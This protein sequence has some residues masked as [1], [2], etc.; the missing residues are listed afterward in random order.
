MVFG[1]QTNSKIDNDDG[2]IVTRQFRRTEP[3]IARHNETIYIDHGLPIIRPTLETLVM[4]SLVFQLD[5][6]LPSSSFGIVQQPQQQRMSTFV[7]RLNSALTAGETNDENANDM[8]VPNAFILDQQPRERRILSTA[9]L[10]ETIDDAL[11]ISALDNDDLFLQ[12]QQ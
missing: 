3:I 2:D 6:L 12:P 10:I 4:D 7:T 5:T 9:F 8:F 1:F 11:N